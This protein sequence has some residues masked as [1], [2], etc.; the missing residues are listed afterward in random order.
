MERIPATSTTKAP[1]D[2]FTGDVYYDVIVAR[3][4]AVTDPGQHRALHPRARAPPGTTTPAARPCTSPTAS[5]WSSPR[6]RSS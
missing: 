1:A 2:W 3:R 5:A 4:G 6:T